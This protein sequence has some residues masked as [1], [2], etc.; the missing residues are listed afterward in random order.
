MVNVTQ[1]TGKSYLNNTLERTKDDV[2]NY[3]PWS[4]KLIWPHHF[5]SPPVT[6]VTHPLTCFSVGFLHH[7]KCLYHYE[8]QQ[9]LEVL[10]CPLQNVGFSTKM[11]FARADEIMSRISNH[12]PLYKTISVWTLIHCETAEL[13]ERS[14]YVLIHKDCVLQSEFLTGL[15][16]N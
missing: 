8:Y 14:L 1:C 16:E 13:D 5:I 9:H 15:G 4:I 7:F 3:P 6:D 12:F 10:L 2:Q 11:T